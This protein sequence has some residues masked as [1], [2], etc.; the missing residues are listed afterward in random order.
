[1]ALNKI[2][3]ISLILAFSSGVYGLVKSFTMTSALISVMFETVLMLPIA[4]IIAIIIALQIRPN[5]FS[6]FKKYIPFFVLSGFLTA[7]PLILFSFSK[8]NLIIH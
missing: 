7:I 8:R 3:I 1:M 4:I 5:S 6:F 2:P